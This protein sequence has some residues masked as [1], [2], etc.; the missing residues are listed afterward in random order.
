V[1]FA[2]NYGVRLDARA[3]SSFG[4]GGAGVACGMGGCGFSFGSWGAWQGEFS[5]AFIFAF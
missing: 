3:H 4:S 1:F 5:A 2:D